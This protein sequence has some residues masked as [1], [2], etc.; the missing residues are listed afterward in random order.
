MIGEHAMAVCNP[1]GSQMQANAVVVRISQ[2]ADP[3]TLPQQAHLEG[4]R[5][6]T[7]PAR[8]LREECRA[9]QPLAAL[10]ILKNPGYY[11]TSAR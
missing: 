9:G 4:S 2:H 10:V 8:E 7:K 11:F 6:G 3:A 5:P 1:W